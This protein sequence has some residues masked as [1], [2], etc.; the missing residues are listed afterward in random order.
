MW[1]IRYDSPNDACGYDLIFC[2]EFGNEIHIEVKTNSS[3]KS[4]LDF[5]ITENELNKLMTDDNYYI[6][7]LFDIKENPKCHIINKKE[8]LNRKDEFFQPVLYKVNIDVVENNKDG[9]KM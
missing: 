8:I 2:D 1:Q 7:Y 5:Y 4:Y 6:Y 9:E 3:S